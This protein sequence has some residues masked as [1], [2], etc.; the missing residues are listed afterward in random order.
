MDRVTFATASGLL[1]LSLALHFAVGL[2]SIVAGS[3]ALAVAKGGRVHRYSGQVF[4]WAMAALGLSAMGIGL[5]ERNVGQ[6]VA[7]FVAAYL[8]YSAMTTVRPTAGLGRGG[9]LVLMLLVFAC[10][11]AMLYGGLREWLDPSVPVV[12]RPRVVP[13]LI[14]STVFL[15]AAIGDLRALRAGGLKG[16]RRLSRHLWRMC[17]GLFIATGSFFLGQMS[18]IPEPLRVL[19]LLLVLAFAPLPFLLYW[20]WRV[21]R[22]GSRAQD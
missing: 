11:L 12:G 15:I 17:F 16:V 7:G 22:G 6:V 13:P 8:V 9:D 21:R 1:W 14:G 5:V 4:T 3:V 18:F 2:V 10:G 20:L 19:P